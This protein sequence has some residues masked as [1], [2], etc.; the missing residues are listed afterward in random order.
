VVRTSLFSLSLAIAV[1]ASAPSLARAD[2]DT[3]IESAYQRPIAFGSYA[4]GWAGS[5]SAVGGGL[6]ARWE[7]VPELG[8]EV[9]GETLF[10]E[11]QG[12]IRHDHPVGFDLFIPVMITPWLRFRP[13][14]GFCAVFSLVEPEMAHAPR[15]DDILFG[16]HGGAG[17]EAAIGTWISFFLDVQANVWI[18]HDRAAQGWTGGIEDTYVPFGTAQ[19][20]LGVQIHLGD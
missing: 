20:A 5:Y 17:L 8:V 7:M 16:L 9:F 3:P 15:A 14:F 4:V 2:E 11:H 13:L 1:A 10:V 18:G 19:V 6:R 12:G